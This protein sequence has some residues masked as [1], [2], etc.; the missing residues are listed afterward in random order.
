M[1]TC[2]MQLNPNEIENLILFRSRNKHLGSCKDRNKQVLDLFRTWF[3]TIKQLDYSFEN[4]LL[5]I[6]NE[7]FNCENLTSIEILMQIVFHAG[8]NGYK[9][10]RNSCG[11]WIQIK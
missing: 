1:A 3:T 7:R 6:D 2:S 11:E 10:F 4:N 5:I 8:F 9:F